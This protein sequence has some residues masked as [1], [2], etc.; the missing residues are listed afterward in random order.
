MDIF[1]LSFLVGTVLK[2]NFAKTQL[3]CVWKHK[4]FCREVTGHLYFLVYNIYF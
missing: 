2:L 3:C 4:Y 1:T